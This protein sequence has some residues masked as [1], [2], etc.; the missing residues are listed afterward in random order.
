MEGE[1]VRGEVGAGERTIGNYE[2]SFPKHSCLYVDSV[3][4]ELDEN[5]QSWDYLWDYGSIASLT[6]CVYS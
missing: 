3:L 2:Y 5:M 4:W 1:R 6:D